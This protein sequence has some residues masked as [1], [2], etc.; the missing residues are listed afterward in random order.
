MSQLARLVQQTQLSLC[1]SVFTRD[2]NE[3]ERSKT[4]PKQNPDFAKN[5][6]KPESNKY[7][8]MRTEPNPTT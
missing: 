4:G 3:P 1:L 7:A 5:Q 6:T 2:G 8:R